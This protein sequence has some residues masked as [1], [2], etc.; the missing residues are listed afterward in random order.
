MNRKEHLL[1]RYADSVMARPFAWL[2]FYLLITL[3][4]GYFGRPVIKTDIADL[5]PEHAPAVQALN[6]AKQRRGGAGEFYTIAVRSPDPV[7]NAKFMKDLAQEMEQWPETRSVQ[8]EQDQSFFREHALLF[9][10]VSDLLNIK[11]NIQRLIREELAEKNPL[12]VDLNKE[13]RDARDAENPEW[14]DPS[15][16][17]DPQTFAELGLSKEEVQALFPFNHDSE[18]GEDADADASGQNRAQLPEEYQDFRLSPDGTVGVVM[19]SVSISSTDV[20]AASGLYD[21]GAALIASLDPTSYHPSM[22]AEVVGAFRDFL[23]VRTLMNDANRATFISLS[24]LILILLLLFRSPRIVAVVTVPLITG[25]VWSLFL[26]TQ[27]FHELNTLT[28]FIFA[29]LVGM[30]VDYSIHIYQRAEDEFHSGETWNTAIFLALTRAGRALLTAMATTVAALGVMA[31]SNFDGFRE[32]GI[33]CAI[34]VLT[35]LAA[36]GAVLPVMIGVSEKIYALKRNPSRGTLRFTDEEREPRKTFTVHR[37]IRIV[38]VVTVAGVVLGSVLIPQVQFEYNFRNLSGPGTG[39]TIR[40]SSAM[41]GNRSSAP[42]VILGQS[43]AQMREVHEY[44]RQEMRE[45]DDRIKGFVTIATFLPEDQEARM[46][47]IDDIYEILDR[48]AVRNMKGEA[49]QLVETMLRLAETDTYTQD[50]LPEWLLEDITEADGS[51]GAMGLLYADVEWWNALKVRDFQ[52]K[53]GTLSLPNGD[54]VPLASNGFILDNVVRY[55]QGDA[56]RLGLMALIAVSLILLID[57]R[58]VRASLLCIVTLLSGFLLSIAG[59][60]IF[61]VKLGLYNVIVIPT[62][63]GIGID[64]AVHIYHRFEEEGRTNIWRVMRSTGFAVFASSATTIAGFLGLLF[65]DHQGVQTIGQLAIIGITANLIVCVTL[66]PGLLTL[67]R[68]LDAPDTQDAAA[69]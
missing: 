32:F 20:D 8:F 43:E 4:A 29:M 6:E 5:L 49:G 68:P 69:V 27:I 18:Q 42:A 61:D 15:T 63:M 67:Y 16:W 13:E 45:G 54:E 65:V 51:V 52:D 10:P 25:I 60:V 46:E 48:R 7:A 19:A 33:A 31:L 9:L 59:L 30:G 37:L 56:G 3:C 24:V 1:K 22:D 35:C 12:Y 11:Q 36:T 38:A 62:V 47:V 21:R 64:G 17:V 40:Y 58:S 2:L 57:L 55:V 23:E 66:L 34:G 39:A 28:A 50:D 44:L 26:I 53:Y 14:R 41:G